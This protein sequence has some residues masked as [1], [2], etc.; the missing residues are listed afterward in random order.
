MSRLA[1]VG[2][3]PLQPSHVFRVV[4]RVSLLLLVI[5]YL[6]NTLIRYLL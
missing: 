1:A 2:R 5:Y 3:V 6:L 4:S